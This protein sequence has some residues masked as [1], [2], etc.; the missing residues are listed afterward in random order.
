MITINN[1]EKSFG[2][3]A[4]IAD[5]SLDIPS[6]RIVA[7]IG[8]NGAGKTTFL[9]LLCGFYQADKGQIKLGDLNLIGLPTHKIAR[10]GICR[11]FQNLQIFN[12]MSCMENTMVGTHL[13]FSTNFIQAMFRTKKVR[14]QEKQAKKQAEEAL[15][16]CGLSSFKNSMANQL[17]YGD[18]K[19]LEIARA[20]AASP[21]ILLM[22][23]PAAG[24]N[25]TE[26]KQMGA[27]LQKIKNNGISVILVEHNMELVMQQSDY[28]FVLD[29]GSLL[30]QGTPA[31]IQKNPDVIKAYLGS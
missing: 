1:L 22:D 30:S 20:I 6:N 23:E 29:F 31:D 24:L 25:D 2:G 10:S 11:T 19:K 3:V 14:I 9:N 21:K 4:A 26:T 12:N 13:N 16:F 17:S 18:L 27:L 15:D 5:I 8:P 7:I 28:I